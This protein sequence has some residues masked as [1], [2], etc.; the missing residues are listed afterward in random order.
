MDEH[1][2]WSKHISLI[3]NLI[4][5]NIGIVSRI[6]PF[7]T[8]KIALL[9]YFVLIYPY[10]TYCNIVWSSTYHSH[11]SRL[12]VLQKRFIRIV[13]LLPFLSSAKPTFVNN[14]PLSIYQI[15]C[16][17][18]ALFMFCYDYNAIPKIFTGFF[19][20]VIVTIILPTSFVLHMNVVPHLL[21]LPP[22]SFPF[23]AMV[24]DYILQFHYQ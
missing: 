10:L 14:N 7:I 5:K 4:A 3:Q 8:T 9:L 21:S 6:R 2:T 20:I 16:L 17:H 19:Q 18:V 12:N 24:Q 13:L 11:L 15:H 23:N 22:N 1:L